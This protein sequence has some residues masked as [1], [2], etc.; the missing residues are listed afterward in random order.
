MPQLQQPHPHQATG[1]RRWAFQVWHPAHQAT[2][3]ASVAI[4]PS[5]MLHGAALPAT[6]TAPHLPCCAQER[7]SS[8]ATAHLKGALQIE[9]HGGDVVL[10]Q[11]G[12]HKAGHGRCQPVRPQRADDEQPVKQRQP[13][14]VACTRARS[15]A[16]C[17]HDQGTS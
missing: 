6:V 13:L 3:H 10:A 7:M 11:R 9:G 5:A 1:R 16:D 12:G 4:G 14:P 2:L 8:R 15:A 17:S